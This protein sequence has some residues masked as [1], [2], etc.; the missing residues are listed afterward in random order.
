MYCCLIDSQ[1]IDAGDGDCFIFSY[2]VTGK[3]GNWYL[4]L[5]SDK[6]PLILAGLILNIFSFTLGFS[7]ISPYFFNKGMMNDLF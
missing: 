6:S 2:P 3:L 4:F 5:V 1:N 7:L